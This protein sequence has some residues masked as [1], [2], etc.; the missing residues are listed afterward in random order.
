MATFNVR[1]DLFRACRLACSTEETRFYLQGVFIQPHHVEG[2]FLV[3][4]DGHRMLVAHDA[5]GTCS[6]PV[7]VLLNAEVLKHA[8]A[9]RT[10][11]PYP[12]R[13]IALNEDAVT[14][15]SQGASP[16]IECAWRIDHSFPDWRR[17]LPAVAKTQ[18]LT[19]F[20]P[21]YLADFGKVADELLIDNAS[22]TISAGAPK[23]PALVS[24]NHADIFGVIMPVHPHGTHDGLPYFMNPEYRKAGEAA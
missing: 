9:R 18:V 7:T 14:I 1:A 24:F 11:G 2:V 13:V 12:R 23:D 22:I 17:V 8:K 10:D 4:T 20:N 5:E 15:T 3:A 16:E 21:R 19:G 6:E